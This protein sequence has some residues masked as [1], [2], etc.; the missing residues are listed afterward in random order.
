[1]SDTTRLILFGLALPALLGLVVGAMG[2]KAPST[3]TAPAPGRAIFNIIT[4]IVLTLAAAALTLSIYG[5]HGS[6]TLPPV[7]SADRFFLVPAILLGVCL[8]AMLL[9]IAPLFRAILIAALGGA[10]GAAVIGG[11][12]YL[13]GSLAPHA[14]VV[15]IP[16]VFA[17]WGAITA[18]PI[19]SLSARSLRVRSAVILI[20][21]GAAVGAG[22]IGTGSMALG[23]HGFAFTAV[24]VGLAAASLLL[25][26]PLR[27]MTI[28]MMSAALAALMAYGALLSST[29][30]WV[31]AVVALVPLAGWLTDRLTTKRTSPRISATLTI[32]AAAVVALIAIAPG[33]KSLIDFVTGADTHQSE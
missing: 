13:S 22:L 10:S 18:A 9:P 14:S 20:G 8:L 31:V 11:N 32:T 4:F 25:R 30:W 7:S 26:G 5:V 29:P 21:L 17:L 12:A 3:Q 16:I 19:V 24:F 2:A 27:P 23:Q 6:T 28:G 33:I 15:W 1:M